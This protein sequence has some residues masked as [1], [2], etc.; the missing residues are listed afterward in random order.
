M[1]LLGVVNFFYR[2]ITCNNQSSYGIHQD[3]SCLELH[4]CGSL[5]STEFSKGNEIFTGIILL[6]CC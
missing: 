6:V 4:K 3:S 5:H 1:L 2:F